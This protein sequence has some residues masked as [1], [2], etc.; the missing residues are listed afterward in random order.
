M[1]QY[2][3]GQRVRVTLSGGRIVEGTIKAVV[4]KTDGLRLQVSFGD[5]TALVHLWQVVKKG[6]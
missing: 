6:H 1:P 4:E 3:V 2:K 5:E